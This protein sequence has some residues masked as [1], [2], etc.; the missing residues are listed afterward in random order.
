MSVKEVSALKIVLLDSGGCVTS[1]LRGCD[2]CST[3]I[4]SAD[5]VPELLFS[6]AQSNYT[7]S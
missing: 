5:F 3:P 7:L 4:L 2:T 6:L 1:R